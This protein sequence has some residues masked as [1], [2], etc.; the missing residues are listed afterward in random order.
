MLEYVRGVLWDFG[1]D[2]CKVL[3]IKYNSTTVLKQQKI[4][5]KEIKVN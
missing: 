5:E 1:F 2:K 4:E 3:T